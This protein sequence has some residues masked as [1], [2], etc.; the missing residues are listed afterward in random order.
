MNKYIPAAEY[1]IIKNQGVQ[2]AKEDFVVL[3]PDEKKQIDKSSWCLK[4]KWT[5][6]WAMEFAKCKPLRTLKKDVLNGRGYFF[7]IVLTN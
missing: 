1:E 5:I 7:I 6:I 3:E 2:R 4:E